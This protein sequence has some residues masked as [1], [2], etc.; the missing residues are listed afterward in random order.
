MKRLLSLCFALLLALSVLPPMTATAVSAGQAV[1]LDSVALSDWMSAIRGETNITELTVP[2]THDSCARKFA[3]E[4]IFGFTSRIA[5]CQS[6]N[7]TEQLNAGVRFLDIRCEVDSSTHSVKTV[8][9]SVDC[10]NG[11]DYYYLDFLFR[12]IYNWLDEHPSESVFLMIKE[13]DGNVGAPTFTSAIYEYIHGYGQNKYFYGEDYDYHNYWYLDKTVPT[14]NQVRGKIVLFNRFDR[15]IASS[16]STASEEESGQKIKYDNQESTSLTSPNYVTGQDWSSGAKYHVQD[17]Y[18]LSV[19]DKLTAVQE[20]LS[21]GHYRGEYY[22]NFTSTT[23]SASVPT[24]ESYAN[25][26]NPAFLNL[27]FDK[28]KPSGYI[29]MDFIS[30]TYARKIV[31]NNEAVSNIVTGTDGN[32]TYEINRLTGTLTVSGNGAMNSYA[33]D[34]NRGIKGTGTTAPWSDQAKNS[35]FDGQY[36]TDLITHIV[37]NDGVTAIGNYAFYGF[38][39]LQDITLPDG[40]TIGTDAIPDYM[41]T[42]YCRINAKAGNSSKSAVNPFAGKDLSTGV[43]IA[44]TQQCDTDR[45]WNNA[46]M[47]FTTGNNSDNRYFILMTNGTIL[48]NDGNGGSGGWNNCYFDLNTSDEVNTTGQ[49]WAD[50]TV[51]IYKDENAQ[52]ILDYYI[53]GSLA[54]SYNLNQLCASGYP[55]GVSGSDGIFSF[56]A[57][58]DIQL[59]YGAAYNIYNMGGTTDCYLD[60]VRMLSYVETDVLKDRTYYNTFTDSLGAEAHTGKQ[61]GGYSVYHQTTDN[62][63]R[64]GTVYFPYSGT[65]AATTNYAATGV[66]PFA[67]M[68]YYRGC[69]VSFWQRINGNYWD[70]RES[71]TFARGDIGEKKYFTI[72]TDGYIRFNN[73]NGGSDASLTSA[74]LYFDY[75]TPCN[76]IV[77]Q[78]WQYITVEVLDDFHFKLYVNGR[79]QSSIEVTGT[80][81]YQ[82]YGGLMN[83][84]ASAD[85]TLYLGSYTPYWGTPTLSLDNVSCYAGT[86]TD[87]Q[88]YALYVSE[89]E[90][91]VFEDDFLTA[92]ER[93]SGSITHLQRYGGKD[94]VLYIPTCSADGDIRVYVDGVQTTN[95]TNIPKNSTIRLEYGG[96]GTVSQWFVTTSGGTQTYTDSTVTFTLTEDTAVD[97]ALAVSVTVDTEALEAA[98][99]LGKSFAKDNYSADSYA[100]LTDAVTQGEGLLASASQQAVDAATEAI[101]TAINNLVPYL[102]FTLTEAAGGTVSASYDGLVTG[103]TT[104]RFTPLFGTEIRLTAVAAKSYQFAG[105]YETKTHRI[106]ST[107]AQYQ[108]EISSNTDVKPLFDYDGSAALTFTYGNG[109]IAKRVAKTPEQ[110]ATV[111]SIASLCPT[112]P[113]HFGGA[114]GHWD[115]DNADI[116]ARLAAGESVSLHP[117]YTEQ[118]VTEP[119]V[120][121]PTEDV[122]VLTLAMDFDETA[123]VGSFIMALGVPDGCE[124]VEKGVAFRYGSPDNFNP[125]DCYLTLDNTT[126]TSKFN[127]A[128]HNGVYIVNARRFADYA[129]AARAY[130]TYYDSEGVLRAAYSEQVNY[131]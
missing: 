30:D 29:Q 66:S 74:G 64:S 3:N 18:K 11:N 47:T 14:L 36:N 123:N 115:Y 4:D 127:T 114:D 57:S 31:E 28:G 97:V 68:P 25:S 49:G 129:W 90:N 80:A 48:F 78:Q 10:W 23:T 81:N 61:D 17:M 6:L 130:C 106:L 62:N 103:Q 109:Y 110:W 35:L 26:I 44:Y 5:K 92:P 113:Y 71:I 85:T 131:G 42:D 75:T 50:I 93:V 108:F 22:L 76:A 100:A 12:D 9:G 7:I 67:D 86:L 46:L 82:N 94:G 45:G 116:L 21:L 95:L 119:E 96:D 128:S 112:V 99:A 79:L 38:D 13:D 1:T 51:T 124:V 53:N 54:K 27:T 126:R 41:N 89:T 32:I 107:D 117:V 125:A 118:T 104:G 77:K 91:A 16:G 8:H 73:G 56:L 59:Y 87:S 15:Y 43:T 111:S 19:D 63:G 70:N 122:P 121:V 24:P 55:N 105:W 39:R 58:E 101:L 33:L 20:N 84:M 120:P 34:S 65:E 60:N 37:V 88:V 40:V 72:G 98:I 83:F 52:H 102:V 2:G 69:T